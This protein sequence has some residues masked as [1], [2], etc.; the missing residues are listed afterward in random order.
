MRVYVL[1][2]PGTELPDGVPLTFTDEGDD[3]V[4]RIDELELSDEYAALFAEAMTD[5]AQGWDKPPPE[6]EGTWVR[7]TVHVYRRPLPK[8]I[9]IYLEDDETPSSHWY[10]DDQVVSERVAQAFYDELIKR[11]M[12]WRRRDTRIMPPRVKTND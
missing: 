4:V 8:G 1:R 7:V 2:V 12:T 6:E 5:L 11:S 3:V 9:E 10:F